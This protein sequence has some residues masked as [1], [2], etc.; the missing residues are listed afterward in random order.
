MGIPVRKCFWKFRLALVSLMCAAA[1]F[2][3]QALDNDAIVRLV[4]SGL[5]ENIVLEMVKNQ[6]GKYSLAASDLMKLRDAG[7]WDSIV[8]AM[9][10]KQF[11]RAPES[12]APHSSWRNSPVRQWSAED[13][14]QFLDD[15]PWVKKVHLDIVRSLSIFE[16]RDGGDW[17]AGIGTGVGIETAGF[18]G[19]WREAR[20]VEHAYQ[21]ANLGTV[22]VRWESA[23]AVR[24][25]QLMAGDTSV[26]GWVG[27]YYAI[28][29]HDL[30]R[31]ARAYRTNQ[32]KGV[33]FLRRENQKDVKPSRVVILPQAD[34][35]ATFVYLFPRSVGVTPKERNLG[36]VAQIGRLFVSVNFLPEDM[37]IEGNLQL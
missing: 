4:K 12:A 31:S 6:L 3:Q 11:G 35:L 2:A 16:R 18:S 29:V 17:D 10:Q 15:S 32:L 13:A 37:R 22:L 27:D 25:A 24:A 36:F 20:A 5:S 23:L 7:V 19:D 30:P 33:A 26:P 9:I 34:G 28:G 21:R 8:A 14:K 1:L